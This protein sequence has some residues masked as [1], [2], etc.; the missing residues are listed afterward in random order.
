MR[1]K[2]LAIYNEFIRLSTA[3]F[4]WFYAS[5]MFDSF[6]HL[7]ICEEDNEETIYRMENIKVQNQHLP[8][9]LSRPTINVYE[10]I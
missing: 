8:N 3:K 6:N 10:E 5:F 7:N 1:L 9:S 4:H 2:L